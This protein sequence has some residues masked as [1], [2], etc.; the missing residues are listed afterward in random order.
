MTGEH[1]F[2]TVPEVGSLLRTSPKAIYSMVERG[3]LPG[4]T[5]IGKRVLV[6]QDDLLEWLRQKSTPSLER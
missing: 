1:M 5:R 2:L 4:V 6:R 3:Q